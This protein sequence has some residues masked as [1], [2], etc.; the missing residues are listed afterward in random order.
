MPSS[1]TWRI[2]DPTSQLTSHVDQCGLAFTQQPE[3]AAVD[4]VITSVEADPSGTPVKVQRLDGNGVAASQSGVAVDLS[5]VAGTGT[6]H[7][8]LGGTV[9]DSTNTG[10]VAVFQP[11]IDRAGTGYRLEASASGI[12]SGDSDTFDIDD[13]AVACSGPCS[14][15]GQQGATGAAVSADSTDGVLKFS[16]GLDTLDCNDRINHFYVGS[17]DVL[18]F[19][20]TGSTGRTTIEMTLA[21]DSATRRSWQYDVCFSS[22]E[23]SFTN[24]YHRPIEAGQAG[25]LPMCHWRPRHHLHDHESDGPCVISKERDD[26]GNVVLTF[27]VPAGDPRAKF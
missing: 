1:A 20:V 6:A 8:A 19:N 27:S 23:S 10:G 12:A 9:S 17:S 15:S 25:L 26:D 4:A 3:S 24:K 16:F 5:I 7:A 2:Q 14:G 21:A 18:T 22:P 13:V 11:T